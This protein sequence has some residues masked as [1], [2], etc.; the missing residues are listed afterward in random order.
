[1]SLLRHCLCDRN[2]CGGGR[3]QSRPFQRQNCG[4]YSG[5]AGNTLGNFLHIVYVCQISSA[6]ALSV[7]SG[8]ADIR[9]ARAYRRL[10][11][12]AVVRLYHN[13][14]Q[15]S[16]ENALHGHC[17]RRGAW[18][19]RHGHCFR[20]ARIL[21]L[22]VSQDEKGRS[23]KPCRGRSV[24]H[25]GGNACQQICAHTVLFAGDVRRSM[26]AAAQHGVDFVSRRNLRKLLQ[27][28]YLS[29]RTALQPAALSDLRDGHVF[30][31]QVH[32][33]A[34]ALLNKG[35]EIPRPYLHSEAGC[36]ILLS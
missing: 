36:A 30:H 4:A 33:K 19:H 25:R 8:F 12:G 18:R 1:M 26:G 34:V 24:V 17:L 35:A 22:Q 5:K 7:L 16:A 13:R 32:F 23:F 6:H 15:M 21:H 31:L 27:L 29:R 20:S 10:C 28:L 14:S 3:R 11:D 2:G 9:P